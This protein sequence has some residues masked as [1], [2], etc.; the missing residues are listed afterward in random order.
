MFQLNHGYYATTERSILG[1]AFTGVATCY[2]E[3]VDM[4]DILSNGYVMMGMVVAVLGLAAVL[5]L[6]KKQDG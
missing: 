5:F 6:T 2:Q 1:V 4:L 3:A